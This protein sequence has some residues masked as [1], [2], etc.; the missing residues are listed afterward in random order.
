V[1]E[2]TVCLAQADDWLN[3]HE[4]DESAF[5]TKGWLRQPPTEKQ[6]QYLPPERRNDFGLTRYHA[7]ALMT[8]GFN[9][10]AIRQLLE[11]AAG[12]ARRAA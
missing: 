5:K 10:R 8:F 7:S 2:R 6:L 4:S 1:G 12:P 11:T 3:A 9:K